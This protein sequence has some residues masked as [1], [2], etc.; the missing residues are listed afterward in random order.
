MPSINPIHIGVSGAAWYWGG[1]NQPYGHKIVNNALWEMP[2]GTII[3]IHKMYQKIEKNF[4]RRNFRRRRRRRKKRRR[5]QR[6]LL[7]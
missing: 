4:T 3:D 2:F 5:R 6:H 7:K 1:L